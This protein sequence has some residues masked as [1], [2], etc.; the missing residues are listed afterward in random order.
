MRA[1]NFLIL[2]AATLASVSACAETMAVGFKETDG[3]DVP[4][5]QTQQAGKIIIGDKGTFRKT[6]HGTLE[7]PLANIDHTAPSRVSVL[8]G[9]LAVTPGTSESLTVPSVMQKAAFWVD[10]TSVVVTGGVYVSR[11]CDV[12]ETDRETDVASLKY[13]YAKPLWY[14]S[15][16][17]NPLGKKN[18]LDPEFQ[19][20]GNRN[21]VYFGGNGSGQY[22]RW[23]KNSSITE[24]TKVR[25]VFMVNGA[26]DCWGNI[27]GNVNAGSRNGGMVVNAEATVPTLKD[28][29]S[30]IVTRQDLAT[31]IASARWYLDGVQ[32]DA[33]AAKPSRGFHLLEVEA[34]GDLMRYDTFFRSAFETYKKA[35]G[36]DFLAEVVVFTNAL[37]ETE[38]LSV[39]R[40][41]MNKWDLT[42]N[43]IEHT[44]S[45]GDIAHMNF[46]MPITQ[47]AVASNALVSVSATSGTELAP[48]AFS[49]E[50]SVSLT[51]NGTFV[52]GAG[53][54]APWS[55]D[56]SWD[57]L[58]SILLRGGA[59]PALAI[60]SGEHYNLTNFAPSG[61]YTSS[62]SK[63]SGYKLTRTADAGSGNVLMTGDGWLPVHSVSPNVRKITVGGG[64][65]QLQGRNR[66]RTLV[67]DGVLEAVVPNGDFE[68]PFDATGE[69]NRKIL[70]DEPLN[71][72]IGSSAAL[73][74]T[75]AGRLWAAWTNI[76]PRG[77]DGR[78]LQLVQTSNARTTVNFPKSG[79]YE[80]SFDALSR[81]GTLNGANVNG[82][83]TYKGE[84]LANQQLQLHLKLGDDWSSAETFGYLMADNANYV[85]YR[86]RTPYIEAGNKVFG[87][88]SYDSGSDGCMFID[89]IRIVY[90]EEP[91]KDTVFRIP[92]GD[93][94]EFVRPSSWSVGNPFVHSI[95]TMLNESRGW[96]LS[97]EANSST[98][99]GATNSV[100][101]IVDQA[102]RWHRGGVPKNSFYPANDMPYGTAAL[103]F[104]KTGGVAR[105]T[106]DAPAGTYRLSGLIG[107]CP[108]YGY[109]AGSSTESNQANPGNVRAKLIRADGTIVDLGDVGTGSATK[110]RSC[111]WPN[112]VTFDEPE[113]VSLE[114]RQTAS[115]GTA[116]ID[117][118]TLT[119]SS[120]MEFG[121]L[122]P[123]PGFEKDTNND[124]GWYCAT[125][126]AS[127]YKYRTSYRY[128]VDSLQP[129]AFGYN[130]F[131][132][133]Y[134][135][136]IQNTGYAYCKIKVPEAGLYR[137]KAHVKAREDSSVYSMNRVTLWTCP[138][139]NLMQTNVFARFTSPYTMNW[140]EVSYLVNFSSAGSHR[141]YI[142]GSG[143]G[144]LQGDDRDVHIDAVSLTKVTEEMDAVPSVP[145]STKIEVAEGARLHLDFTGTLRTGLLKLGNRYV[146]G[147]V[148]ASTHPEYVSGLGRIES[149]PTG[150]IIICK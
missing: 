55:G 19:S 46:P 143:Q 104:T 82:S 51:G 122:I 53:D 36:G 10:D 52:I 84:R 95:F 75:S 44:D 98:L 70:N 17:G 61:L 85:R 108:F 60:E 29:K 42:D 131:E 34:M 22:M 78:I 8:G 27:V 149:I 125:D 72:W 87:F 59:C 81:Y 105:T 77:G 103:V 136:R 30:I 6:G 9:T 56:F 37:T 116:I 123:D 47:F 89:N 20:I 31:D 106:F 102:K 114:L 101:A 3:V 88:R 23:Y 140:V 91:H 63:A 142:S 73:M 13:I 93:F 35:Q 137:F 43:A 7:L 126:A 111:Y 71:Y 130:W 129:W 97:L 113:N 12:R 1:S 141:L 26:Y 48:M 115:S 145:V 80:V 132:G 135:L 128:A 83:G 150:L 41:L 11:W 147:I 112:A 134:Y 39:E 50:G 14:E 117:D 133:D 92:Y 127:G 65:L 86:F 99:G 28:A 96:T 18:G 57:G 119:S 107:S 90:V 38:R 66:G 45:K 118:L 124:A 139:S 148:D 24:V 64:Q 15:V 144:N 94:D 146:R 25:S 2:T 76:L 138:E 32:V 40:Y 49:G 58:G 33:R 74:D 62:K 5:G 79:Y 100:V 67:P 110:M 120:D 109:V 54:G 4:D 121:N 68:M 69:F 21:A 16:N